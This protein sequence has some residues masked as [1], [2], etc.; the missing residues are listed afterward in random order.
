MIESAAVKSIKSL[1]VSKATYES[2]LR[3]WKTTNKSKSYWQ[4]RVDGCEYAI[5][6]IRCALITEDQNQIQEK[7]CE[8]RQA[9]ADKR[10]TAQ[11]RADTL[12][13]DRKRVYG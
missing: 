2:A 6:T 5:L 13:A 8:R 11:N 9:A 1:Q 3:V 12:A 4:G 10:Q 7:A